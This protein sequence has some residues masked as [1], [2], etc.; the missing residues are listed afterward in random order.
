MARNRRHFLK[1]CCTLGAAG[2]TAQFNRFGML[3]AHAQAAPGYQ[4]LVCIFLF[5]GNDANNMVVPIDS[6]YG[7]YRSMRGAVALDQ[8]LLLPAS[9]SGFGLHPSLTNIQRYFNE[10]HA[11]MVFNVGTLFEPTTKDTLGSSRLPRNLYSHSD[12]TQQW[13][14]S[15]PNGGAT[16][17]GGRLN[18]FMAALNT[19]SLPPGITVNG[20]NALFLSGSSTRGVNFSNPDSFGLETFGD[21]AAMNARVGALQRLLTFDSGL[22]LVSAANGVLSESLRSAQEINAALASAPALPV[23]FPNSGLGQQ[24]AQVAQIMSV[25]G[26]LGMNRQIFFAGMGGFDNHE[27]LL[28]RHQELMATLDAAVGPFLTTLEEWSLADR[29]T[30]FTESEF[31][32]TGDANANIGTDHAWGSHHLVLGGAVH[33]GAFGTFPVHEL[34]GQDDAGDRGNWIPTTSLDQYAATLGG[35][36]GVSDAD[37]QRILPNLVNFAPQRLAFL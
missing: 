20:G 11:A 9:D 28:N 29:V 6:R 7:A 32:R 10:R 4:A 37:L 13:Q 5:G 18:D 35:W 17:W 12:Q 27:D 24:L 33:G 19:G 30:V 36:F 23:A 8:G 31:N 26:S 14:S 1:T 3:T 21:G 15:D 2:V 22:R 25:R 16:G 34:G